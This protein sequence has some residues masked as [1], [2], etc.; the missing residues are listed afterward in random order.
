MLVK[1]SSTA[2]E[3]DGARVVHAKAIV[4]TMLEQAQQLEAAR[5]RA[6]AGIGKLS[7]RDSLYKAAHVYATLGCMKQYCDLMAGDTS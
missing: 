3:H 5:G 7:K 1:R 2:P 6:F 4:P